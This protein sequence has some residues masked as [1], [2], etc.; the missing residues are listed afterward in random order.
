MKR[1]ILSAIGAGMCYILLHMNTAHAQPQGLVPGAP[2]PQLSEAHPVAYFSAKCDDKVA[3]WVL[4]DN[5]HL[6]RFDS[7]EYPPTGNKWGELLKQLQ[8]LPSDLVDLCGNTA[9]L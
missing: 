1:T 3:I 7:K 6:V 4:L 2:L 9:Q 8:G 5:G